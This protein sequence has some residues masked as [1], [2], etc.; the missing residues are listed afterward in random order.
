M[1]IPNRNFNEKY[2][3]NRKKI[4]QDFLKDEE[5]ETL[6]NIDDTENLVSKTKMILKGIV[7]GEYDYSIIKERL[8]EI[9]NDLVTDC[10]NYNKDLE[11]LTK[12][13][14]EIAKKTI[15]L[16][17]QEEKGTEAYLQKIESLKNELESKEFT[18]QNMERIYIELETIIRNN[19]QKG[20]DQLLPLEQFDTFVSQNDIIK[21]ECNE[22]EE[23]KNNLLKEYN[24]LLRENLNLKSKDESFEIEK[25][26][27]VLEEIATMGNLHKEAEKRIEKLNI[28]YSELTQ[29][30]NSLTEQ[31][32]NITKTL[33]GLNIDNPRLNK[34]LALISKEIYPYESR[35]NRTFTQM[36]ENEE[37]KDIQPYSLKNKYSKTKKAK[38]K[39]T[40]TT[41]I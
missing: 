25:I 34:E 24:N 32:K 23:E 5:T 16:Q 8:A 22:L 14:N 3:I 31:I 35:L 11:N 4:L 38:K 30:C 2:Y 28:R 18:I 40:M 33:E 15:D 26:K 36:Y 6:K 20:K 27:D 17:K 39:H 41:L 29:E 7:T 9:D 10:E 19:M 1:L 21:K 37:W 12:E 13:E